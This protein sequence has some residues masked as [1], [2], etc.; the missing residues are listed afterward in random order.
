MQIEKPYERP[1]C[2]CKKLLQHYVT[3]LI[4]AILS[5]MS[6][7]ITEQCISAINCNPLFSS[8]ET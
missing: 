8:L 1:W 7:Y 3:S 4:A 6:G 5:A 2:M